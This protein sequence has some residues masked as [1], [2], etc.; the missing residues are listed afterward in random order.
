MEAYTDA[1]VALSEMILGGK[2]LSG[3]ERHCVY[4]NTGG[5]R[6]ANISAVSGLDFADDGRGMAA[7]DWD[8]DGDVD[9]WFSNR[10]GP[11]L[12]FLRN[13][14]PSGNRFLA[15]R[16][17]GN[18]TSC[19]RDAIGARLELRVG[20]VTLLRTLKAGEGYLSQSSKWVHFGLGAQGAIESLVVRW[21]DGARQ[22]F[23]GL[24][25][26]GFY[27]LTQGDSAPTR[28]TPPARTRALQPSE[29]TDRPSTQSMRLLVSTRTPLPRLPF[30]DTDGNQREVHEFLDKPL[31]LNLWASW[32]PPCLAELAHFDAAGV[33][34]LALSVDG[35]GEDSPTTHEDGRAYLAQRGYD[36]AAGFANERL[37]HL[38]QAYHDAL[39]LNRR[40]LPVPTSF[41]IDTDGSVGA[42]YKGVVTVEQLQ[43]DIARLG[44]SADERRARAIPFSGRWL[45]SAPELY[46][47][48]LAGRFVDEGLLDEAIYYL[49]EFGSDDVGHPERPQ[50]LLELADKLRREGRTDVADQAAAAARTLLEQR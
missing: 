16:L 43:A 12:R 38:L 26:S 40:L 18:G 37:V 36:F 49:R 28:W 23:T 21:P 47:T 7:T 29:V 13:D 24:E 42:I 33:H 22:S 4:L 2:S 8:F 46:P 50:V 31:L 15:I 32:C 44:D 39:Y 25:P 1:V 19:N 30:I 10:T 14:T 3:R 35:L 48:Q 17:E 45:E 41:L 20:G 6:F 34:M 11:R 9:L 27:E 5:S